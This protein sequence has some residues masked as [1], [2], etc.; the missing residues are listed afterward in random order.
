[1]RLKSL[2]IKDYGILKDFDIDFQNNLSVLIGE[3]G[4]GKSS[5]IECIA[6]IFGHLHK[7]FVLGDKTAEF[8]DGYQ[9][10]YEINA[11]NVL[12]ESKYV[13]SK[14]NTFQPTIKING[15]K[16][17][18]SQIRDRYGNFKMFLPEKVILSYSGVTEHL[19]ELNKHFED[20]FIRKI[21]GDNSY[22]LLPLN[23]PDVN[24]FMYVKKEYVSFILLALFVLNTEEAQEIF[25]TIGIDINGCTTTITLKKPSW[26]T[27]GK[28]KANN[29]LWGM[30]GKI[31]LDFLDGLALVGIPKENR[32]EKTNEIKS[33][34]F[35]FYGSLMIQDLFKS[36]FNLSSDQ[37]VSFLDTLLCDDL[38]RSVNITWGNDLS[39]DRLSEGEKQLIL[40]VGLGLVLNKKNLLFLYDEPDVS[41]H[42]KWQQ[43]F[44]SNVEK[45]LDNESMAIITTHSPILVSNLQ[46]SYIHIINKGKKLSIESLYSYGRDINS[47][48]EDYFGIEERNEK[49]KK[50]IDDFYKAMTDKKYDEAETILDEIEKSFGPD[51]IATI[52]A[53][54]IFD[55]LA[56]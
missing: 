15:N 9:I 20:K 1:M 26:A 35:E 39:V 44:I 14:T 30:S 27:T 17:S 33:I 43:L 13:A 4:S 3:N 7:Y 16:L 49:G 41:L 11:N 54:S 50:I 12:I 32:D 28:E 46:K 42:P 31:A 48:L 21:I 45:G 37:V 24:P 38:L 8:I 18:M 47:V 55:D 5:I 6:Y 56:E 22:S 29:S 36:Y 52:K 40:S 34:D 19:K 53:N 25:K 51:D 23:L 2:H 10:E